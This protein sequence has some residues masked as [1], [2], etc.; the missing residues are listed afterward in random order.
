MEPRAT[1]EDVN[2]ILRL[3]ELR[4][5]EKLRQARDW[6][7]KSFKARTMEEFN[8]L[9]PP[10]SEANAFYRM[11]ASYWEMVAS[12]ITSG[13]LNQEL[14]FQSGG[15]ILFFWERVRDLVPHFREAFKNPNAGKNT[16][17]VATALI[18]WMNARAPEAYGA[19]SAMV[20][21]R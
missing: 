21:G 1:Y 5:E 17:T 2:L 11:V 18:Q 19:F 12:F 10:G 15:E 9:C 16:E 3:F 6:F 8:A 20:R 14:F 13:V 4:R 7:S